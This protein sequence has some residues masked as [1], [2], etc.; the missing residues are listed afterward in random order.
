MGV[1]GFRVDMAHMIPME[2]WR[3]AIGRARER[4]PGVFLFGE[5]YDNDPAKLTDGNVLEALLDAGFDAVYDDP[6]YDLCMGLYDGFDGLKWAN[7][8]D[9]LAFRGRLTD[10]S[11]R[12]AENHDEVRLAS[13]QEWGGLGMAVGRPVT[14]ALLGTTRGPLMIYSGQEVG[15]PAIG[16]EGFCGDNARTSIFDYG[17]I[18]EFQ[19]WVN[20]GRFDG[21][22][23]DDAKAGLR[24]W[25]ADF[26][27]LMHAPAFA[28]GDFYGLNFAN[29][30]NPHFGRLGGETVSGHWLYAWLRRDATS[31]EAYLMIVNFH[32]SETLR[33]VHVQIP[34]H[35]LARLDPG[36]RSLEFSEALAAS[37]SAVEE[38]SNL[39]D[40]G[41][42]LPPVPPLSVR[43]LALT[44]H[45]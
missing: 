3:W 37:W 45:D 31:G 24:Q 44:V 4:E 25:Y 21:G 29:R 15:E 20:G 40:P 10:Q 26:L 35:A 7:D 5:A 27:K 18:P 38:C 36:A 8:L 32:G 13:P 33:N 11:L 17:A 6:A 30:E 22:E 43:A 16:A 41:L 2:F 28:L 1:S 23:L 12:Y 14:A 39:T 42:A 19:K 9:G 34:E